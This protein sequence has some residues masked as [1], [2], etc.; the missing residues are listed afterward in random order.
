MTL[1]VLPNRLAVCRLAPGAPLAD[2]MSTGAVSSITRTAH[3]LSVVCDE[4]AVPEG[5]QAET[6]WR[7]L[8]LRGPIDFGLT[9]VLASL[10]VPLADAEVSIF[11]LSTYDT[12]LVLVKERQLAPAVRAI[13]AA[14]AVVDE[15]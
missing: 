2:W 12:D 4:G 5:V 9:G 10:L 13:R 6:G 14:G 1:D 8:A 3:E 15:G 11:A 7:A